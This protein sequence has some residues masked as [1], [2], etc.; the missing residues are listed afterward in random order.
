VRLV[1][2]RLELSPPDALQE[3]PATV[4]LRAHL[5][6]LV[7]HIDIPDLVAEVE[8]WTGFTGKLSHA[9]GATHGSAICSSICTPRCSPQ[10]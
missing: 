7:P 9:A 8:G 3:S 2:D 6:R 5:D 1:A 4:R 10:G